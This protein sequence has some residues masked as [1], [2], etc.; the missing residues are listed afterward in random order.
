M[1]YYLIVI[2]IL[3]TYGLDIKLVKRFKQEIMRLSSKIMGLLEKKLIDFLLYSISTNMLSM[4]LALNVLSDMAEISESANSLQKEVKNIIKSDE[5]TSEVIEKGFFTGFLCSTEVEVEDP[6]FIIKFTSEGIKGI[7]EALERAT[8]KFEEAMSFFLF[9]S[10]FIPVIIVQFVLLT[11]SL[12]IILVLPISGCVFT[13]Y[14]LS[15]G[16]INIS[17]P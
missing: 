6:E 1:W 14:L 13:V 4:R 10:F 16:K 11:G 12:E 15:L 8:D 5:T 17:S 3:A 2:A 7:L 9:V